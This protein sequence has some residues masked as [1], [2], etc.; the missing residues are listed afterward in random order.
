[1]LQPGERVPG[2]EELASVD[3]DGG[4]QQGDLGYGVLQLVGVELVALHGLRRVDVGGQPLHKG[5][6]LL[7]LPVFVEHAGVGQQ[8]EDVVR[9]FFLQR[10]EEAFGLLASS[11]AEEGAR[12][13]RVGV[14]DAVEE[15]GVV[16]GVQIEGL[17]LFRLPLEEVERFGFGETALVVAAC[18]L[19]EDREQREGPRIAPLVVED[20]SEVSHRGHVVRFSRGAFHRRPRPLRKAVELAA[21][22]GISV[23]RPRRE[24]GLFP[25][26]GSFS[27]SRVL[28][29]A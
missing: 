17:L 23:S 9:A 16:D 8:D 29:D 5:L 12:P 14:G 7:E 4:A 3:L 6:G 25:A 11:E 19:V 21:G 18:F 26:G 22:P 1:V 15:A 20:D 2:V 27:V 13:D 10:G 24:S 28:D